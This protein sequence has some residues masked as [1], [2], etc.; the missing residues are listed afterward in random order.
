MQSLYLESALSIF[1][2]FA[3]V[4]SASTTFVQSVNRRISAAEG[5]LNMLESMS[6]ATVSF[7][8]LL[9]H[10][11]EVLKKNQSDIIALQDHLRSFSNYIPPRLFA[12]PISNLFFSFQSS[13]AIRNSSEFYGFYCCYLFP[14]VCS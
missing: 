13:F 11:N 8:E 5:D 14:I 4:D 9:G 1:P 12:A 6:F 10:C 2:E 7:E 3:F